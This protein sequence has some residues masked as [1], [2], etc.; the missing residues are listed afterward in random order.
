MLLKVTIPQPQQW[1]NEWLSSNPKAVRFTSQP[2]DLASTGVDAVPEPC[3]TATSEA[4]EDAQ[5]GGVLAVI[6]RELEERNARLVPLKH[7]LQA[8]AKLGMF[9]TK[10]LG[11]GRVTLPA[12][13]ASVFEMET[14][15]Q[16]KDDLQRFLQFN[17]DGYLL[18]RGAANASQSLPLLRE[19]MTKLVSNRHGADYNP[20]TLQ[21][22][23]RKH[24][25]QRM[26]QINETINVNQVAIAEET[27]DQNE[28]ADPD[29]QS[30]IHAAKEVLNS[31]EVN[32]VI[33]S[34]RRGA[35]Q[36]HNQELSLNLRSSWARIR[37]QLLPRK[38]WTE[39]YFFRDHEPNQ[40]ERDKW[41]KRYA[42]EISRRKVNPPPRYA[43]TAWVTIGPTP[44]DAGGVA[45][46]PG[47]HHFAGFLHQSK[48]LE[49]VPMDFR[50][51]ALGMPWVV[52]DFEPG[53]IPC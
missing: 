30:V 16:G 24:K 8:S 44:M 40:A 27:G 42:R 52:T 22:E 9:A 5:S 46:C 39:F 35:S 48:E 2:Y 19:E 32:E 3:S 25:R 41:N 14:A 29:E 13:K 17:R 1:L 47:S 15:E 49:E 53:D 34:L 4:T 10:T 51:Q 37:G 23:H 26:Q 7:W 36:Y 43:F 38:E 21:L 11:S 31:P 45:V 28:A 50:R 20:T 33:D 6:K 12:L 18:V